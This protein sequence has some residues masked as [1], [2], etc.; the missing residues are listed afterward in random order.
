M[1]VSR[2]RP[3]DSAQRL[4]AALLGGGKVAEAE[5]FAQ[6]WRKKQPD[7]MGFVQG[8]GDQAMAAG[9]LAEAEAAY[10]QVV[11]KLPDS[12]LAL[13]NLAYALAAQKK[14]GGVALAEKAAK[15]APR[16]AAVLDTLATALA[17]EQ[18][19]AKAVEVQKQVVEMA[20]EVLDYRL[21]LARLLLQSGD[22][23]GARTELSRLAAQGSRYPRQ[24]EVAALLKGGS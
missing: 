9:K 14:P 4:Y 3:G 21:G 8:M 11:D 10:R 23:V 18:Q 22:K 7:D 20:P 17:A 5:A 2:K 13:N 24:A 6:E 16:N 12:V 1:A 15:L 19:V